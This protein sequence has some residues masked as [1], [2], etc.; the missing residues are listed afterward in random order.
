[1]GIERL[2]DLLK[3]SYED[4]IVKE[5]K[6]GAMG[7]ATKYIQRI[8][9]PGHY[10]YIYATRGFDKMS[11]KAK[12]FYNRLIRRSKKFLG[13]ISNL[14]GAQSMSIKPVTW[15]TAIVNVQKKSGVNVMLHVDLKSHQIYS[16]KSKRG[17]G[18]ASFELA[19]SKKSGILRF[20]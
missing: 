3:D 12:F 9:T 14:Y 17:Q 19:R 8:G 4:E 20:R 1:M 6:S 7:T 13:K 16:Y 15:R 18:G 5:Y 2:L 10:K 11:R